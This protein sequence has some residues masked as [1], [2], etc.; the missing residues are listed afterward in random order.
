MS[1]I[2]ENETITQLSI[3]IH[4]RTHSA[5][6]QNQEIVGRQSESSTKNAHTSSANPNRGRKNP[7]TSSANQSGVLRYPSRQPITIEYYVTRKV[8]ARMEVPSRL[9]ARIGS[10]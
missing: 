5:C 4:C 1:H 3:L 9:W 6:A 2:A 10:L 7:S 8:A